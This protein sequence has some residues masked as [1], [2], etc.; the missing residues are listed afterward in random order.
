MNKHEREALLEALEMAYDALTVKVGDTEMKAT[1]AVVRLRI[2]TLRSDLRIGE[3]PIA[4]E[5]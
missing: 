1:K 4:R 5:K 3:T 2:A